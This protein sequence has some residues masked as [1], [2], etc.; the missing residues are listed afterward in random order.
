MS[1]S[2]QQKQLAALA[3]NDGIQAFEQDLQFWKT[4]LHHHELDNVPVLRDSSGEVGGDI[5]EGSFLNNEM[6]GPLEDV[7]NA[8][9]RDFPDDQRAMLQNHTWAT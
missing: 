8:V 2:P 6:C 5:N 9:K 1:L 7:Q 3:A 4:C